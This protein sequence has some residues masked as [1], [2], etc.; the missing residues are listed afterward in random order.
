MWYS[1]EALFK[2]NVQDDIE[3]ILYE[4]K[5]FLINLT[6]ETQE[7]SFKAEQV[8]LSFETK[9]KNSDGKDV[10]WQFIRVVEVQDLSE[11]ELYDGIEV[12]SRLV[13]ENEISE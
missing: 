12:F 7:V 6:D 3:N 5:I 1:V 8:A 11:R 13:W 9:Y 4:K 10:F 2:C